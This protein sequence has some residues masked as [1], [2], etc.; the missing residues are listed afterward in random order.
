MLEHVVS[1]TARGVQEGGEE[2]ETTESAVGW[3]AGVAGETNWL[4]S[5]RPFSPVGLIPQRIC[6]STRPSGFGTYPIWDSFAAPLN[7]GAACK[8]Q[9]KA[10]FHSI[11]S[12]RQ[13]LTKPRCQLST[14]YFPI[15]LSVLQHGHC[16]PWLPFQ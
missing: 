4:P 2:E 14:A 12:L 11:C 5:T 9:T 16:E 10:R 15:C 13:G 8:Y 3:S 1:E 7:R 6:C